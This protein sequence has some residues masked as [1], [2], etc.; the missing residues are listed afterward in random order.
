[1]SQESSLDLKCKE[2]EVSQPI[3]HLMHLH[4]QMSNGTNKTPSYFPGRFSHLSQNNYLSQESSF[5]N[6][7]DESNHYRNQTN[8][9]ETDMLFGRGREKA[10][11]QYQKVQPIYNKNLSSPSKMY[12]QFNPN[13]QASKSPYR[14]L[15]DN[16]ESSSMGP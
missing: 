16:S 5:I 9:F 3:M 12:R 14:T 15:I 13:A 10:S 4:Q 6:Q 8:E 2:K 11:T 7:D 1:M